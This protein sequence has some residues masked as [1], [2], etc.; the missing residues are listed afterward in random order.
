MDRSYALPV[1]HYGDPA[2]IVEYNQIDALGCKACVKHELVL[3]RSVCSDSRNAA[4]R[5]VPKIGHHCK[6]FVE[7]D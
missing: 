4:Q 2:N 7:G 5:G 3:V 6:W 1:H